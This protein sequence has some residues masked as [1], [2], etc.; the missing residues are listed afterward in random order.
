[1]PAVGKVAAVRPVA[2]GKEHGE[3]L[4]VRAEA[5]GVAGEHVGPVGEIGDAPEALGLALRAQDAVRCV[6]PHQ[7]R[8]GVGRDRDL[9]LDHMRGPRQRDDELVA[10]QPPIVGRDAVD[11]DGQGLLPRAV[12]AQRCMPR[13]VAGG[14]QA[15]A[16]PCRGGVEP[17]V[18][19]QV[20]NEPVR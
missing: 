13:P 12:E 8:V 15:R 18:E 9:R 1:M 14:V 5:H 19:R 20:G 6:E 17:E 11:D 3:A 2:I 4:T 7:L 16:D 10:V